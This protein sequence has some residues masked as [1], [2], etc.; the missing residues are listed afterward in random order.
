M[1]IGI[2]LL[3]SALT[4][5]DPIMATI[6]NKVRTEQARIE[7]SEIEPLKT[8]DKEEYFDSY[9]SIVNEY[10]DIIDPPESIHDV[11]SDDEFYFL[12]QVVESEIGAGSFEQKCNVASTI[13]N[14]YYS[15]DFPDSFY[16]ILT[17]KNHYTPVLKGTY[18]NKTPQESTIKAIE[19]VYMFGDTSSGATAFHSGNSKWHENN[20]TY[21]FSDGAHKFYK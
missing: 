18:K 7:M 4:F 21:V 11:I 8:T 9:M 15:D 1:N 10:S 16:E 14:R 17:I 13:I 2:L 3:T 5:S 20:M 19:Y 12:A 6:E